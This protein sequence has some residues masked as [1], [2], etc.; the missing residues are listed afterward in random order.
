[1]R[2]LLL[3]LLLLFVGVSVEIQRPDRASD[4][5]FSARTKA[6]IKAFG[7]YFLDYDFLKMQH[8]RRQ[9]NAFRL[10]DRQFAAGWNLRGK[11]SRNTCSIMFTKVVKWHREETQLNSQSSI[12][13][14]DHCNDHHPPTQSQP[15]QIRL[16]TDWWIDG[17]VHTTGGRS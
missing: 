1:M 12:L 13:L 15:H 5:N 4:F 9:R 10:L 14:R 16:M 8:T 7:S 6:G 11:I 17:R 2:L 3:L